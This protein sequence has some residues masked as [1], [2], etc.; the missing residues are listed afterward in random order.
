MLKQ[1]NKVFEHRGYKFN[2]SV[3]FCTRKERRI[4]GDVWHT[5][6]TND[7][8]HGSYYKKEEVVDNLLEAFVTESERLARVYIDDRI[9]G[10]K[11]KDNRLA[12]LGFA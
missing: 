1:V 2:T 9:D 11:N 5:V 4:N 6:I 3:T 8:G 10:S 7:M 12:D